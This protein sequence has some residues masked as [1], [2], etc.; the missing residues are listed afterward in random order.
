MNGND[1]KIHLNMDDAGYKQGQNRVIDMDSPEYARGEYDVG[2]I[3]VDRNL[4]LEIV[5]TDEKS[6]RPEPEPLPIVGA[7]RMLQVLQRVKTP[8]DF[9]L[10]GIRARSVASLIGAGGTGKSMLALQ[11]ALYVA[12][13][14]DTIG[15]ETIHRR[16]RSTP[17][18]GA[19]AYISAEDDADI[20]C[21]RLVDIISFFNLDD[22]IDESDFVEKMRLHPIDRIMDITNPIIQD[23]IIKSVSDTRL[24]IIDTLRTFNALDENN[25][26]EMTDLI[27]AMKKIIAETGTT[28]LF[29]H[30]TNK[31]S[32]LSGNADTQQAIRGSS[33]LTDNIRCQINL[34]VMDKTEAKEYGVSEEFRKEYM[35]I[36]YSKVNYVKPIEDLWCKRGPGGVLQPTNLVKLPPNANNGKKDRD[37]ATV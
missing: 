4:G 29:L 3:L 2:D 11:L 27:N 32:A 16:M 18:H 5:V 28:I 14:I 35:K 7:E 22:K 15:I 26:K 20:L 33:V 6:G 8:L 36:S 1:K 17:T 37:S 21:N 31:S 9:V 25:A 24:C 10:P 23:R 12:T 19:V 13:G 30:H 34:S